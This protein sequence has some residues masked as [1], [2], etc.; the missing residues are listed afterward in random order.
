[1]GNGGGNGGQKAG[2]QKRLEEHCLVGFGCMEGYEH[3]M[4][5]FCFLFG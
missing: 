1:M 2:I 4:D 3:E 5:K